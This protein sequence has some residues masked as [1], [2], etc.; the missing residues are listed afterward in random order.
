MLEDLIELDKKLLLFFNGFHNP[1]MDTVM[2]YLTQTYFWIPLYLLLLYLVLKKFR[3]DSWAPLL[4]ILLTILLADRITAGLMKPFFERL[5][6]SR[7]PS[8]EGLVHL[9]DGYVGGLYGFA[10][11]HA[12]NTFGTALFFWLLFRKEYKWVWTLFVWAAVMTYTRIYLGVHYPGDI[13]VGGTIGILSAIAGYRLYLYL[14]K[15]MKSGNL[16]TGKAE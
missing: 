13:L 15:Y 9:V 14:K 1:A 6:P 7:E 5:R 12:A 10:S 16:L 8:L 2:Y 4:G 3:N 11:S